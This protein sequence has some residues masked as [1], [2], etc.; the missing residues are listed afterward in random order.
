M[1]RAA[2]LRTVCLRH[3]IIGPYDFSVFSVWQDQRTD[4]G[5]SGCSS[6]PGGN[7]GVFTSVSGS[8]PNRIFNIEW[9]TVLFADNNATQNH[10][11]RLYENDPNLKFEVIIGTLNNFD[12]PGKTGCRVSKATQ[13]LGSLPR[14]S[15]LLHLRL[16]CR[17]TTRYR[18]AGLRLRRRRV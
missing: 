14:T 5:L 18:R 11:V 10:E 4:F 15:A 16:T 13:E 17:A 2:T 9:R 3:Q 1:S 6:F 8:A 12:A 7:C